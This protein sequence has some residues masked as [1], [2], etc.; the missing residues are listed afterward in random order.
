M[1]LNPDVHSKPE[2][3]GREVAADTGGL[4]GLAALQH[5]LGSSVGTKSMLRTLDYDGIRETIVD[6]MKQKR[7]KYN[8][9]T[10]SDLLD[11]FLSCKFFHLQV[12][13]TS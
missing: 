12:I 2:L 7:H 3:G 13:F 9:V 5:A 11:Q 8:D 6:E 10:D 1:R 4:C